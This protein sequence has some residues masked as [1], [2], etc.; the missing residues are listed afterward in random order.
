VL[1]GHLQGWSVW[2]FA[3]AGVECVAL[4]GVGVL[5]GHLQGW[6]VAGIEV[7]YVGRGGVCGVGRGRGVLCGHLQGQ[8]WS[9]AGVE[10]CFGGICSGR[11]CVCWAL[12]VYMG[13]QGCRAQVCM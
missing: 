4:A 9:V 1:C 12:C 13:R 7:C 5:C 3:G 6:S 11:E 8:G 10:V 2:A